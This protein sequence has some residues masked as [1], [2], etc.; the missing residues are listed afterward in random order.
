M[1]LSRGGYTA[2]ELYNPLRHNLEWE[3]PGHMAK[4]CLV[5][6]KGGLGYLNYFKDYKAYKKY[7]RSAKMA[8]SSVL[9]GIQKIRRNL[10]WL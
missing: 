3:A 10:K 5:D 6:Q 1:S 9:R 4:Y 8:K 7:V 2:E